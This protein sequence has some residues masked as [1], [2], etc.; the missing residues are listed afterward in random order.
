[1]SNVVR[2]FERKAVTEDLLPRVNAFRARIIADGL[3]DKDS[4]NNAFTDMRGL[5]DE[6]VGR[7][8][9]LTDHFDVVDRVID[10]V[11]NVG[12]RLLLKTQLKTNRESMVLAILELA[13]ELQY[14]S[15]VDS[16]RLRDG[17]RN[18]QC[19]PRCSF[20]QAKKACPCGPKS[21]ARPDQTK[22]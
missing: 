22:R 9:Q 17:P 21:T 1:M 16:C 19:D 10:A 4:V 15:P 12:V 7:V 3:S 14:L 11:Q 6:V 18:P 8:K 5:A 13:R 20:T 2:L